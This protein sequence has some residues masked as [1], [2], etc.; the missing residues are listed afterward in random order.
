MEMEMAEMEMEMEMEMATEM[1]MEMEMVIPRLLTPM[2]TAM[3]QP[4]I[5]DPC[6][7]MDPKMPAQQT[8]IVPSIL[9]F[10]LS[11]ESTFVAV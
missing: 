2:V 7:P 1:E 5:Q 8:M 10:A 9:T 11:L 3:A 4:L 6:Q